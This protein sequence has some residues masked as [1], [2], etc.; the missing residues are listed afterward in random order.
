MYAE[1]D[2]N[3]GGKVQVKECVAQWEII[4]NRSKNQALVR[5]TLPEQIFQNGYETPA[6]CDG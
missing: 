5:L 4:N 3:Y 6:Y 1:N 2:G